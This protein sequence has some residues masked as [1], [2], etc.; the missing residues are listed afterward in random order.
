MRAQGKRI[1]EIERV[2]TRVPY[3]STEGPLSSVQLRAAR[4]NADEHACKFLG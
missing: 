2:Y 4:N 3:T 1:D